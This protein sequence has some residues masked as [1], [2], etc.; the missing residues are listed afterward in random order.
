MPCKTA[1]KCGAKVEKLFNFH[2]IKKNVI[3]GPYFNFRKFDSEFAFRDFKN[4]Q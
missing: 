4:L 2:K 3:L 1:K